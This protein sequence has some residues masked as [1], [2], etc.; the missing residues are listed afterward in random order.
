VAT[1]SALTGDGIER[2]IEMLRERELEGGETMHLQI[3]HELSRVIAKLHS[4]A[5]VLEQSMTE[6]AVIF[7]VWVPRDQVHLFEAY[8]AAN[9]LRTTAKAG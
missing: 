6:E 7:D 4:V 1:V 5:V 2:L 3:P 9:L 8:A